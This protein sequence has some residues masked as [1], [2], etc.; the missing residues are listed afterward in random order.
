MTDR[1]GARIAAL[2]L[3]EMYSAQLG[4]SLRSRGHDVLAVVERSELRALDDAEIFAWAA[5]HGRRIVTENVR[6]FRPLLLQAYE[7]GTPCAR[8]LLTSSRAFPRSRNNPGPLT[9]AIDNWLT[10][11]ATVDRSVE[12]WLAGPRG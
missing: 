6:D 9:D 8:L 5:S 1:P 4:S 2:L 7:S 12:E 10:R 11:S 3:D